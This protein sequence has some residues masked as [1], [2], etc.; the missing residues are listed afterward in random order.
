MNLDVQDALFRRLVASLG[1]GV[2]MGKL[3]GTR[4][5]PDFTDTRFAEQ[6]YFGVQETQDFV[7]VN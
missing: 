6:K 1:V 7:R 3:G 2:M 4:R 5:V